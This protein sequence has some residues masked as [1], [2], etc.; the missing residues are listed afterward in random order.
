MRVYFKGAEN[1]S[2]ADVQGSDRF[3]KLG[4]GFLKEFHTIVNAANDEAK[5]KQLI[6]SLLSR[7]TDRK[8]DPKLWSVSRAGGTDRVG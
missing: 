5:F 3:A 4:E 2:R 7:H 8:M 1:F 6:V